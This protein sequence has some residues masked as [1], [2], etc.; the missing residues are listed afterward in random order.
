MTSIE[1]IE[2]KFRE[3]TEEE[4]EDL[5][6]DEEDDD[7]YVFDCK[8]PEDGQMVLLT[9]RMKNGDLVV[10]TD[11]FCVDDFGPYFEYFEDFDGRDDV[12][13]IAWAPIP[14]PFKP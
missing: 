7:A 2:V 13:I 8:L 4:R 3:P 12:E 9:I 14:E 1:W 6:I 11:T 5:G 10:T